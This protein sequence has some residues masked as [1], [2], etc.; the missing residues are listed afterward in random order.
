VLAEQETRVRHGLVEPYFA[1][2]VLRAPTTGSAVADAAFEEGASTGV[3]LARH[4]FLTAAPPRRLWLRRQK[5]RLRDARRRQAFPTTTFGSS[6]SSRT[7]ST[8]TE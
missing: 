4:R 7:N 6:P 2:F 8:A 5:R 1:S 3:G